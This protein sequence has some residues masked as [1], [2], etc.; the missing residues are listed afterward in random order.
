[1][2]FFALASDY[3]GTIAQHGRVSAKTVSALQ[4]LVDTGRRL[5][6]VTGRELNELLDIFPEVALFEWVVAENG[7]VLY[8]PSNREETLLA[9][10][11]PE[12]FVRE[13]RQRR[14]TPLSVGRSIVA[15]WEPHQTVVLETIR[16]QG[17]DLQVIFNKGAVMIL[18][19][20]INKASGLTAALKLMNLTP[21]ETVGIGDAENDQAFL[22]LCECSAAVAN[23]LPSLK[24]RVHL[25][26]KGDHGNG[27]EELIDHLVANDLEAY[28]PEL[29]VHDLLMGVDEKGNEV[30][31]PAFGGTVLIAGPS[32][33]GK[34]T[35]TTSLLERLKERH[36]QFCVIDPEGDYETL[37]FAVLIGTGERGPSTQEVMQVLSAPEH[38]VVVNLIGQK[39]SER[40]EYFAKLLPQLLGQRDHTGRPH[41]L[42]VDEAHHLLPPSWKLGSAFA[43]IIDRAVYITVHP[44]QIHPEILKSA[45]II[46]AVGP[47]PE[48]TLESFCKAVNC[49]APEVKLVEPEDG[50]VYVWDRH[51]ELPPQ[52]IHV[53]PNTT[54][55]KRHI[56]KYSEG[57]LPPERS[58]Y[59]R[60]PEGKLRLRAQNLT[61]FLQPADGVDDETWLHHLHQGDYSEWFRKCIKDDSLA[62][63]VAAF[64]GHSTGDAA[65]TRNWIREAIE[66]R[67]TLPTTAS[68]LASD[69]DIT[70]AP[71]AS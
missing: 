39:L 18:P 55:R 61:L 62:S 1:M 25:V 45:G 5:L 51:S 12:T 4:R 23:A 20:G 56:R 36:Y 57:E 13:L 7:A 30:T 11:P 14:V 15:T 68:R 46:V 19:A 63:D 54:E 3:D 69:E 71:A 26:M 59:F 40:P 27:V 58:F 28:R 24:E 38:N 32:G 17:L 42:I 16:E 37:D 34:S 49:P 2:R 29:A 60:G 41:W 44:D 21:H 9:E 6:L 70:G 64:E 66:S 8:R 10:S 67:Y 31:I 65:E 22:N 52:R 33:S 53:V 48:E 50:E 35:A 43:D 47:R